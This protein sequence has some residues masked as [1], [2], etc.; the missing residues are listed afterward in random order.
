MTKIYAMNY[1]I[2][3]IMN[4]YNISLDDLVNALPEDPEDLEEFNNDNKII[5]LV[6]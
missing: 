3:R 4:Q 6:L 1:N 5:I 2:I